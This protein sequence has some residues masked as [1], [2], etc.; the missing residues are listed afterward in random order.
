MARVRR[1]VAEAVKDPALI[2][3]VRAQHHRRAAALRFGDNDTPTT[4]RTYRQ[5]SAPILR[6]AVTVRLPATDG[7]EENIHGANQKSH[8]ISFRRAP[9][10]LRWPYWRFSHIGGDE[11]TY[12]Q[13]PP[14]TSPGGGGSFE[15]IGDETITSHLTRERSGTLCLSGPR[16]WSCRIITTY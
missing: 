4:A 15:A 2:A 9:N 8:C 16:K 13:Q 10:E 1:A 5:P 11:S 12:Q 6:T 7:V 14:G 3:A